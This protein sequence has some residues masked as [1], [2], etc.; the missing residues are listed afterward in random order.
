[1]MLSHDK[2]EETTY[3]HNTSNIQAMKGFMLA[4]KSRLQDQA[5]GLRFDCSP[6]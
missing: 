3:L 1:M 4:N 5:L 6:T 2:L